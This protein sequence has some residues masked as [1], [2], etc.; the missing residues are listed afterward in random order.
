MSD[1]MDSWFVSVGKVQMTKAGQPSCLQCNMSRLAVK[2]SV[3][4]YRNEKLGFPDSNTDPWAIS[5]G[6]SVIE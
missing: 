5:I 2:R 1:E 4:P 3:F 6:S